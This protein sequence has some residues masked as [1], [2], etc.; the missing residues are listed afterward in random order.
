M[1]PISAPAEDVSSE[2]DEKL[3]NADEATVEEIE[4][5]PTYLESSVGDSST[6]FNS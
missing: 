2:E 6:D 5:T 3:I 1:E 4:D